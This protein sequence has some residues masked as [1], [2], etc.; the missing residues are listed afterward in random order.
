MTFFKGYFPR[1]EGHVQFFGTMWPS[2]ILKVLFGHYETYSRQKRSKKIV[3][4][5]GFVFPVGEKWFSSLIPGWNCLNILHVFVG[6]QANF[7]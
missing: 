7:P 1:I 5:I 2:E 6:Y 3:L 4:K